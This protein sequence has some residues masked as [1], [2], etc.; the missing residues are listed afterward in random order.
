MTLS[1][2]TVPEAVHKAVLETA[3]SARDVGSITLWKYVAQEALAEAEA[4]DLVAVV[5][6]DPR[7]M[8]PLLRASRQVHSDGGRISAVFDPLLQLFAV[9]GLEDLFDVAV[10][11]EDAVAGIAQRG[12]AEACEHLS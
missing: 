9:E 2:A 1:T 12:S 10:T 11:R 7:T 4:W 5:A 8:I 6:M 3:G